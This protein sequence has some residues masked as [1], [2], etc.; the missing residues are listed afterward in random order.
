MAA[1]AEDFASFRLST[2]ALPERE[3]IPIYRE[4]FG[5][6]LL[7]IEVEP[8]SDYPIHAEATLRALPGLR[9]VACIGSAMRLQRTRS[10]IADGDNSIGLVVNLGERGQVC[11]RGR[12][13]ALEDGDAVLLLHAEPATVTY[14]RGHLGLVVPRSALAARVRNVDDTTMRLIPHGT[15]ALRLL[16]DYL[17]LVREELV[18]ATP[19]LRRAVVT[20]I[21]HLVALALGPQRANG[22]DGASAMRAARRAAIL[23]HIA[24][25]FQEPELDVAA[26]AKQPGHLAAPSA[27]PDRSDGNVVHCARERAAAATGFRA[28]DRGPRWRTPDFR[29]RAAG[30]L[31]R[32]LALQ[33]I[34]PR[35]LRRHAERRPRAVPQGS[36]RRAME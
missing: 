21:H 6:G 28:A 27:P 8:L 12:D 1:G 36:S 10:T 7:H 22:E 29:G 26:V 32:H 16:V 25:N 17:R 35:P 18:L 2:R 15:E 33:P 11:Q 3:R 19:E 34:V 24:A 20:H 13:V 31:F 5:R 23:D 14:A 30:R 9:T 4:V